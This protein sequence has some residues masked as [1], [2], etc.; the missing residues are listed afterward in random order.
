[1]ENARLIRF[2]CFPSVAAV[3][4]LLTTIVAEGREL[5]WQGNRDSV[6][7]HG[8]DRNTGDSNWYTRGG[9]PTRAPDGADFATF[10]P[11]PARTIVNVTRDGEE[12]PP[13]RFDSTEPYKLNIRAF[14]TLV[15]TVSASSSGV[16]PQVTIFEGKTLVVRSKAG[17]STD[18]FTSQILVKRGATLR[19][20][21]NSFGVDGSV[22][23]HGGVVDFD[24][25]S[26][27]GHMKIRNLSHDPPFQSLIRFYGNSSAPTAQVINNEGALLDFSVAGEAI[28]VSKIDNRGMLSIGTRSLAVGWSFFQHPSGRLFLD[29]SEGT[30]GQLRVYEDVDIDGH[31]VIT[32]AHTLA[33]GRYTIIST[34]NG[35]RKGKF[36]EVTS[37]GGRIAYGANRVVLIIDPPP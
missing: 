7:Q 37:T 16:L 9:K 36:S 25:N 6:W 18:S 13:M 2:A 3:F 10:P 26:T 30:V 15:G 33:P 22:I 12:L 14:S 23:N 19:F 27:A 31:L 5:V 4:A 1:L 17:F 20:T 28:S 29:V 24:D 11:A 21:E 35:T 34:F 32:G 8:I